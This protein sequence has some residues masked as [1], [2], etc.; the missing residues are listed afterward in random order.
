MTNILTSTHSPEMTWL[1]LKP[2]TNHFSMTL[3]NIL[4][5]LGTT[6]NIDFQL[7]LDPNLINS[8]TIII[9]KYFGEENL[10]ETPI[11]SIKM[12]ITICGLFITTPKLTQ[13]LVMA[14][15]SIFMENYWN[16]TQ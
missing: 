6:N 16:P 8:I 14:I 15:F 7:E 3:S 9:V 11:H 1:G 4:V 12:A 5:L 10:R 13:P 2:N